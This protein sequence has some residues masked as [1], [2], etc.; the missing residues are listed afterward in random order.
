MKRRLVLRLGGI[1]IQGLLTI[2]APRLT[3]SVAVRPKNSNCPTRT[4][5]SHLHSAIFAAGK[6]AP[7]RPAFFSGRFANGHSL[8]SSGF[9]FLNSSALDPGVKPLRVRAA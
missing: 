6:P 9:S 8:I 7:Y 4:G 5:F 3:G 1:G 2:A